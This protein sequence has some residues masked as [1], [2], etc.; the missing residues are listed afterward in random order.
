LG[1]RHRFFGGKKKKKKKKNRKA[2]RAVL[3]G[4]EWISASIISSDFTEAA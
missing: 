2:E 3:W 4:W 1:A